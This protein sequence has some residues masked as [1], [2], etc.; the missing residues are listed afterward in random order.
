MKDN[1][2][3]NRNRMNPV[4]L[5][6]IVYM[7]TNILDITLDAGYDGFHYPENNDLSMIH[8]S[9]KDRT[10]ILGGTDIVSTLLNGDEDM[11]KKETV[12]HLETFNDCRYVFM[13]SVAQVKNAPVP[14]PSPYVGIV[15]ILLGGFVP[16]FDILYGFP[17][18]RVR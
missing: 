7:D 16:S 1:V 11:I 3:G 2:N 5:F 12:E 18:S 15:M 4:T 10:C 8:D 9:L 13:V 17:I 14:V 6:M